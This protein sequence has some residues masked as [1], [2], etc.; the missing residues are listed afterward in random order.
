LARGVDRFL[1]GAI[2]L[3]LGLVKAFRT[4]EQ[5]LALGAADGP[6]FHSRH[7][8]L[9]ADLTRSALPLLV[10]KHQRDLAGV[11]GFDDFRAAL[12]ALRFRFLARQDVALERARPD[13]LARS[14]LLE[15]LRRAPVR[16]EF[17][18]RCLV[19]A[20]LTRPALLL[21]FCDRLL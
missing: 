2:Q 12:V 15:A 18:H 16:F 21:Y 6:T 14:R 4:R 1:R 10:R 5:L 8:S 7:R 19:P 20:G 13:D 9:S 3:A 11:A 17:R